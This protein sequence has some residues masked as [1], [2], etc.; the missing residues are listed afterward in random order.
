MDIIII[1]YIYVC[2]S[3]V[4]KLKTQT[5]SNSSSRW[6]LPLITSPPCLGLFCR[7]RRLIR[8]AICRFFSSAILVLVLQI[9]CRRCRICRCRWGFGRIAR[10]IGAAFGRPVCRRARLGAALS[11]CGC[12]SLRRRGISCTSL[13]GRLPGSTLGGVG[14]G[15]GWGTFSCIGLGSIGGSFCGSFTWKG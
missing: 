1:S 11:G 10:C 13:R 15:I 4:T 9:S 6:L 14:R 7:W 12:I 5:I 3:Q 8:L 2:V